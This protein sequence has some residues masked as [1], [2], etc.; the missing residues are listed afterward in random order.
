MSNENTLRNKGYHVYRATAATLAMDPHE[1]NYNVV[2]LCHSGSARLIVNMIEMEVESRSRVCFPNL[3]YLK[4]EQV[5]D[6]FSATVLRLHRTFALDAAAGINSE[7][8]KK[9]Y[10]EPV[11][12][13]GDDNEWTLLC[14]LMDC[15]GRFNFKPSTRAQEIVKGAVRV[16]VQTLIEIGYT[17]APDAPAMRNMADYYVLEFMSLLDKHIKEEHEVKFYAQKI[18]I[19]AKYLNELSKVKTRLK[20]KEIITRMLVARIKNDIARQSMS[21]SEIA[22]EYQFSDVSSL[23][24]FIRKATG[25]SPTELRRSLM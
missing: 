13:I 7:M 22:D 12:H 3:F 23:G 24:K 14:Q 4:V 17:C 21:F 15:I 8:M 19:T 9:V 11:L 20:A 25:M 5:S 10:V 2:M 18:G 1:S 16:L 6:D